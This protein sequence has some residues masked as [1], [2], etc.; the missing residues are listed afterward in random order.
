MKG[1]RKFPRYRETCYNIITCTLGAGL[2]SLAWPG[3]GASVVGQIVLLGVV[4]I[5]NAWVTHFLADAAEAYKVYDLGALIGSLRGLPRAKFWEAACN[6][7]I[8]LTMSAF[9]A[10]RFPTDGY[11]SILRFSTRQHCLPATPLLFAF[12]LILRSYTHIK[13]CSR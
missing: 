6:A 1:P 8:W 13:L 9:F 2:L 12:R 11:S 4:L 3:A 5:L 7:S 10:E